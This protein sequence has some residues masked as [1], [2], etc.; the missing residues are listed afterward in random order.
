MFLFTEG[1]IFMCLQYSRPLISHLLPNDWKASYSI[2]AS[3]F[4]DV[5]YW[6]PY[7]TDKFIS[8]VV[9]GPSQWFFHFGEEIIISWTH[10]GRVWW[11]FQESPIASG[12]RD[13]WHQQRFYSID[14]HEGWRGSIPSA[15]VFSWTLDESGA[16]GTCSSRQGLSSALEV[17]RGA[18]L[19]HECNTPQW[20]WPQLHNT[21]CRTYFFLGQENRDASIG[22]SSLVR[23][24]VPRFHP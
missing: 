13:P 1:T 23:T 12:A 14:C 24:S 9:P 8:C 17:E 10:I 6:S 16:A 7:I 3:I 19:P 21:L 18:V 22:I 11:M 5:P 20:T 4:I 15:V 2:S